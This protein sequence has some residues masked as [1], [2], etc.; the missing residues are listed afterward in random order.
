MNGV[1]TVPTEFISEGELL[2]G[3][4]VLPVGIGPFPGICKFHGLPGG[5]DQVSGI[6]TDFAKSGFAVLTFDFRG[7]RKSEGIF[8]LAGEIKDAH[9]AVT[10][11]IESDFTHENWVGV[12]G[13][14][15]G[16]AVAICS[17]AKDSRMDAV[18]VRAPVYDP[19]AFARSSMIQPAV[20]HILSTD[21][22]NIHGIRD[23][24]MRERLLKQMIV[25]GAK[26]NPLNE[27][28][29]ISPRPLFIIT[30]D[31]DVGIDVA[32][33]K[34]LF[35]RAN[36]P[37]EFVVVEGADH[38]LSDPIAHDT[39]VKTILSWFDKQRP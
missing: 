6:A 4:F 11:L 32:G 12:Y 23:P 21:E 37:K 20:E 24:V 27:V 17:A 18:C 7:F 34:R 35:E 19:E 31:I 36:D 30:G 25:D 13:A 5:S 22:E 38:V 9:S 3:H 15:Y 26:H 8:S 29:K 28:S 10:H 16:G 14:S 33:V 1:R 2:R 39:T